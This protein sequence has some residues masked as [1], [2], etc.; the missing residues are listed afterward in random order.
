MSLLLLYQYSAYPL[1]YLSLQSVCA[2]IQG[3]Y[4]R[5][6]VRMR[7]CVYTCMRLCA[8]MQLCARLLVGACMPG[9]VCVGC[10]RVNV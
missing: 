5:V 9:C 6:N 10:E 4:L 7:L 8:R 3:V 2:H 1:V